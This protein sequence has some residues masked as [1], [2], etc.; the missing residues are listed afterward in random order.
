M[1]DAAGGS[2]NRIGRPTSL[3]V[4]PADGQ[5]SEVSVGL[6]RE[7]L[8]LVLLDIFGAEPVTS[9]SVFCSVDCR[10]LLARVILWR[11]T[12]AVAKPVVTSHQHP[13]LPHLLAD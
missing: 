5:G 4:L 9:L 8:A 3:Q 13:Q 11:G 10:D 7:G 1:R 6:C 12:K 2:L